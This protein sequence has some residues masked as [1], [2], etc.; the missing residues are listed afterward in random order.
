VK[1]AGLTQVLQIAVA[2]RNLNEAVRRYADHYGI[3]P[4]RILDCTPA[5]IQGMQVHGQPR[6][7]GMRIALCSLGGVDWELLEPSDEHS[8]Y[9]EF[10]RE[11]G[12]GFHHIGFDTPRWESSMRYL[13]T[14]GVPVRMSGNWGG[15]QEYRYLGTEADLGF[16]AEVFHTSP[17]FQH[18]EPSEVYPPA[19]AAVALRPLF[20]AV[21]RVGVVVRDLAPFVERYRDRYGFGPWTCWR[22][23][24]FPGRQAICRIGT[25]EWALIEPDRDR[26]DTSVYLDFLEN[27]GGG[28]HHVVV[29]ALD[30]RQ[31][32]E[33][34]RGRQ[35]AIRST[36]DWI[37][38][39]PLLY[40]DTR[41][42]LR[43]ALEL[44][45]PPDVDATALGLELAPTA[46]TTQPV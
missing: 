5:D 7:Y 26:G 12:E 3:G 31:T 18:P 43:C 44:V 30:F 16:L 33:S 2:V 11:R 41:R 45:V 19:G 20:S 1:G 23:P 13:Q 32:L 36:G 38:D 17:G 9:A 37:D 39:R 42:D 34:L 14:L 40:A 8:I 10:L 6:E 28:L 4:W 21:R 15:R 27:L 35:V 24:G 22:S 25:V 46:P 29:E